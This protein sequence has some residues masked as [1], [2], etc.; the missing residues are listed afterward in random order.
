MTRIA[1]SRRAL[2][3]A[4]LGVLFLGAGIGW[5]A[6]P[7]SAGVIHA[8]RNAGQGG[9]IRVID[10][11]AQGACIAGE[12]PLSWSQRGPAGPAGAAGP[13]GPAGPAGPAGTGGAGSGSVGVASAFADP[14]TGPARLTTLPHRAGPRTPWRTLDTL[15]LTTGKYIAFGRVNLQAGIGFERTYGMRVRCMLFQ[16]GSTGGIRDWTQVNVWERPGTGHGDGASALL[17]G[18]VDVSR[19]AATTLQLQCLVEDRQNDAVVD[20]VQIRASGA[21][22]TAIRV[23]DLVVG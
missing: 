7:D 23:G 12:T 10:T 15:R 13:Q 20:R 18:P 1:A 14:V 8:C 5:A 16:P 11:E 17:M 3:A 22:I 4:A 6:I 2:L 19:A 21:R 9:T